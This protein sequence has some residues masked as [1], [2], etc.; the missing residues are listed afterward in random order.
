MLSV[1]VDPAALGETQTY[2]AEVEAMTRW[3]KASPPMGEAPVMVP[4]DPERNARRKR[5]ADGV[6]IDGETWRKIGEAARLLGVN[7]PGTSV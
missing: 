1:I 6:P 2:Y 7:A 5:L 4:G 3:V